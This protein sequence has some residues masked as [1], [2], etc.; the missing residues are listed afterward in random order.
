MASKSTIELCPAQQSA[1]DSLL[2]GLQ[3]GSIFRL[4]GG[5]GRGKT[6]LL[7]HLHKDTGGAFLGMSDFVAAASL[8]HPL[9][10]EETLYN[11][12]L[13]V[14]EANPVVILDDL[15]LLDLY[16]GGCHFYPRSGYFN[17]VMT[18]LCTYALESDRK[19]IFSTTSHLAE[20]AAQRSYS[21]GID[22]FKVED[23][24][25]RKRMSS[26]LAPFS[27]CWRATET[28]ASYLPSLTRRA[29]LGEPATLVR[30]PIMM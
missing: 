3:I 11:L 15:H 22:R 26:T 4:W 12:V 28:A 25:A 17:A 20:A 1:L 29:N 18:G 2:K 6:T 7:K 5:V 23:Y 24:A 16:S 14:L 30:S 27:T 21:F 10:L 13:D 19:L 9:A 8:K